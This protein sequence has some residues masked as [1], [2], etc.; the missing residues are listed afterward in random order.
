[1]IDIFNEIK[2]WVE[3]NKRFAL[4]TVVK[5]WG[6]APRPLGSAMA[7][8][9]NGEILG[10]VSGGC[11]E[12]DVSK[13]ALDILESGQ[14]Q[15]VH[16]GVSDEQAWTV[17]L[18]CGGKIDV[19]IEPFFAFNEKDEIWKELDQSIEHNQAGTLLFDLSGAK[20]NHLF[21]KANQIAVG[22]I[23]LD[24][25]IKIAK[26]TIEERKHLFDADAKLF[27]QLIPRKSQLIIIGAAHIT[28]DLVDFGN[29][30]GFETIVID[31]RGFFTANTQFKSEPDQ[32]IND[33]PAEVLPKFPLDQFTYVV[34]LSHDPKIDDQA[35]QILMSSDVAYIGAL[36]SKR[37]H[38]KRVAR[39]SEHGF[40]DT[41]IANIHGPVG[42]SI[43]AKTPKEIALSVIGQIL[44][45]KN[46]F[47]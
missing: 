31:P 12:G 13:K 40:S 37:T 16:Y 23:A 46:Q 18:S 47:L 43:N 44:Q 26:R 30:F 15:L 27:A 22:R 10:S 38:A 14:S 20:S 2:Q 5:T 41:Q 28:V 21:I 6:S 19:F 25:E 24:S 17:G 42:L 34:T 1:V 7:I 8:S 11:V 36:G 4:A 29:Q 32:C 35:L 39:L 33:W 45:V 3:S 9:E